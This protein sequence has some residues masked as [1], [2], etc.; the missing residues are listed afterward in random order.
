MWLNEGGVIMT[1]ENII[2]KNEVL[3]VEENVD[4]IVEEIPD[5][6]DAAV[7]AEIEAGGYSARINIFPPQYN[8]AEITKEQIMQELK[9]VG[10]TY[11]IDETRINLV[12]SERKYDNWI[13]VATCLAAEDGVNGTVEYLFANKTE[14]IPKEDAH[15][16]VDF[17]DLGIVRNIYKDTAIANITK[18]T[19]GKP[20]I[21]VRNEPIN[22]KP[23]NP[24]KL[25]Y[26]ENIAVSADGL[27]LVATA[28]GNL[29]FTSGR[30]CVQTTLRMDGDID[31]STGNI[32]FIGDVIV[33]GD[34]KESFSVSAGKNITIQ[35]GAFGGKV[36]AG[37]NVVI[38]KGAIGSV[39]FAGGSVD[40]DF[41]ENSNIT[42]C[43]LL[44]AK[45]LF[46]CEVFC[47][48]EIN[49][50]IGNGSIVG[51]KI[52][53]TKNIFASNIGSKNF[54]PTVIV[55]GD[56]AI[57][58]QEKDNISRNIIKINTDEDKCMKII[59]YLK[60]KQQEQG[61]LPEDKMDLLNSAAKT[62]LL[63]R[64]EKEQ[65]LKRVEEIDEYLKTK[66]NLYIECRKEV[67]PGVRIVINDSIFTV[68]TLYQYCHIGLGN[69]GIEIRAI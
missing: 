18:E 66:Q 26:A 36:T 61:Q 19:P 42:C 34:V 63:A 64:H 21:N 31:V 22:Q 23:G 58:V 47:K 44:K 28:D 49:V 16:V 51:G 67:Y 52:I 37:G 2:E 1:S 39:I 60:F 4:E 45:S 40:I 46:F 53:S 59:E 13:T 62:I 32:D 65:L 8:G 20:G 38:K 43:E 29:A 27:H 35:G 10:V 3:S 11:G 7:N 57:M 41:G 14:G 69:D 48:G 6:I 15:G 50:S 55:V 9:R 68:G 30:F 5:P 17:K 12:L 54:I 56:N 24:A 33:R 25:I